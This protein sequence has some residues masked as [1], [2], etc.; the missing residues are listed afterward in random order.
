MKIYKKAQTEKI[1]VAVQ[2]QKERA[3]YL[4]LID[5][6][7]LQAYDRL[8]KLMEKQKISP[9]MEGKK[10]SINIRELKGATYGKSKSFSIRGMTPEEVVELIEKSIPIT[11][12]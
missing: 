6:S 7:L 2:R 12:N 10:T 11:A 9:L 1:M 5:C 8:K 4:T 3:L